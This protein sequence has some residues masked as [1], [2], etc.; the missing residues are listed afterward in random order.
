MT[1]SPD[2]DG[3]AL[4]TG[5]GVRIGAVLVRRLAADGWPVAIHYN[6]SAAAAEALATEINTAGGRAVTLAGD[7][8]KLD[9]F[10]EFFGRANVKWGF[11]SCS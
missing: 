6:Q 11:C 4:V 7:I 10:V 5:G 3:Y 2:R 8:G 9:S 1:G